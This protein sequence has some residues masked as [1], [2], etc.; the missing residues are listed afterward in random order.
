MKIF[1]FDSYVCAVTTIF[2][3]HKTTF[4]NKKLRAG[5]RHQQMRWCH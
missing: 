4:N 2:D 5:C 1:F 3:N